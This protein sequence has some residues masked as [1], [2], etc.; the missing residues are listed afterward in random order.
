[1]HW[2]K[3]EV[4][5]KRRPRVA[6]PAAGCGCELAPPCDLAR[7]GGGAAGRGLAEALEENR[8]LDFLSAQPNFRCG[9]G[10]PVM[11]CPACHRR[12]CFNHREPFHDG[13]TCAERDAA[14]A[15]AAAAAADEAWLRRRAKRCPRCGAAIEK[16]DGCDHLTCYAAG[17]RAG[18]GHQFCWACLAPYDLIRRDGNHRHATGCAY[19]RAA[20]WLA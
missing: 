11:T 8:F 7:L 10:N 13:A 2:M 14:A 3:R 6:C 18:C 17:G 16:V 12:T 9:R 20:P 5:A 19:H 15:A 4:T 1:M